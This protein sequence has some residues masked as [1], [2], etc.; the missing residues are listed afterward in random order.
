MEG[1][2]HANKVVGATLDNECSQGGRLRKEDGLRKHEWMQLI[3]HRRAGTVA[4]QEMQLVNAFSR[5]EQYTLPPSM[6]ERKIST[7]HALE[8]LAELKVEFSKREPE[9]Q[10][11]T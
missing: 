1:F 8:V 7:E 6:Y 10:G 3:E 9:C 11:C 4:A 2:E 5:A